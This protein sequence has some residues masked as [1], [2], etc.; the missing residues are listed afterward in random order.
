MPTLRAPGGA[1]GAAH[2]I[3]TG[4]NRV[5]QRFAVEGT[6]GLVSKLRGRKP[7]GSE[8]T[9]K[10][11]LDEAREA[12]V[13]ELIRSYIPDALDL[14]FALWKRTTVAAWIARRCE[15]ALVYLDSRP[16]TRP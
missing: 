3:R 12:E 4:V 6:K 5:C 8:H 9:P 14:S 1:D 13:R 2:L 7:D 10:R 11:L 16:R 15:V